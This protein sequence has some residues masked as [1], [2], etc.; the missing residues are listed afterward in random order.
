MGNTNAFSG[1][2][3]AANVTINNQFSMAYTPVLVPGY[4][5]IAGFE[6]SISYVREV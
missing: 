1:Q 3:L 4:G 5:D 6:Q 2:V